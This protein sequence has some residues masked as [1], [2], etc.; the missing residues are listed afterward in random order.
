MFTYVK[1]WFTHAR[2]IDI[3][4]HK[5]RMPAMLDTQTQRGT[6]DLWLDAAQ[7]ALLEGGVEAVK[8]QP[9]ARQ[10][11]LARTSFYWFFTDR[12]ALLTAL[13]ERWRDKNT[14]SLLARAAAYADSVAEAMLNVTDCWLDPALFDARFEFAVRSWALQSPRVLDEVRR[15]DADRLAALGAMLA[16]FGID[17][18]LAEV[19]AR[20]TYLT[21]IGYIAMQARE[22]LATRMARIPAYVTIFCGEAPAPR[23][24]ARFHARHG[25]TPA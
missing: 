21:Q 16:R 13:L 20:T 23:E 7:E 12:E 6:R 2:W 5:G 17:P 19:R 11:N 22:D 10:L 18:A 8:I 24:L 1:L 15:A 4:D 9:L 14:G 3:S 25:Y